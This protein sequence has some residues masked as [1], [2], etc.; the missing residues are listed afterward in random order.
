MSTT[1]RWEWFG[2]DLVEMGTDPEGSDGKVILTVDGDW[3]DARQA[4]LIAAAPDL[5]EA[6]QVIAEWEDDG[7]TIPRGMVRD[8][9]AD[10]RAAIAKAEGHS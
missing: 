9:A 10:A 4:L 8:W 7:K 5:F 1:E 2:A 3:P 6:L